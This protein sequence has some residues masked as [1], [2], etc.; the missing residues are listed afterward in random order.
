[1]VDTGRPSNLGVG[2]ENRSSD[3]DVKVVHEEALVA[4]LIRR[5][6]HEYAW[7]RATSGAQ[8]RRGIEGDLTNYLRLIRA[9]GRHSDLP[10]LAHFVPRLP[11]ELRREE[12]LG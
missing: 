5:R 3:V 12:A 11:K 10:D 2:G 8:Y 9:H 7:H 4:L 6:S 1:M